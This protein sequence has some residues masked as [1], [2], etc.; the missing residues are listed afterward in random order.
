MSSSAH[1][2]IDG[3]LEQAVESGYAYIE[4]AGDFC[5]EELGGD[6]GF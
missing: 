6:G 4:E 2:A 3:V 5:I 1:S